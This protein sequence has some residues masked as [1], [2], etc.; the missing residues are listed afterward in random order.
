MFKVLA[1]SAL[2]SQ[3]MAGSG[4]TSLRTTPRFLS[5]TK[6]AGYSPRSDV[7]DHNNLD[8]DQSAI[9]AALK[10]GNFDSA[11][12]IYNNGAYSK[13]FATLAVPALTQAIGKSTKLEVVDGS[14]VKILGKALSTATVGSTAVQFQYTSSGC[15]VGGL[16]NNLQ[17]TGGCLPEAGNLQIAGQNEITYSYTT[18]T[19]N[20]NARTIRGFST[21]AE[22][23]LHNCGVN[24][25]YD[26]YQKFTNYYEN[27]SY[28][29][30]F[31]QA[32][33]TKTSTQGFARGQMDFSTY[34]DVGRAGT[35]VCMMCVVCL[36][37]F[38]VYGLS[39]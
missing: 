1:L 30:A 25:P 21:G 22:D 19:D 32:A 14:G 31:V 33:L 29:D 23:K 24:C 35:F 7:E 16:P 3:A 6:I 34:N 27:F 38:E 37:F 5:E 36:L 8:Q 13:T 20:Q 10:D 18:L 39:L 2:I 12:S 9:E 28:G 4:T 15:N 11:G 26:T 17:N